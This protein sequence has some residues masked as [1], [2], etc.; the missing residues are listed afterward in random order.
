MDAIEVTNNEQASRLEVKLD[1]ATAFADYRI[2]RGGVV[3]PHTVV[4]E[5]FE[6]RGVGSALVR[7]G[8]KMAR[9]RPFRSSR[10]AAS[11]RAGSHGIRSSSSRCIGA[12]AIA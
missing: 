2:T 6:G 10:P 5:A 4:P 9:R 11:S 1:G 7:A 8:L 3:F 12:T